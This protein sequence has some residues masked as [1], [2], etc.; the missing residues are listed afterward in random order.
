M[1]LDSHRQWTL[2]RPISFAGVSL[3]AGQPVRLTLRPAPPEHGRVFERVDLPGRPR[4]PA[5]AD[6]VVETT[7]STT[8]GEGGVRLATV[9]HLMA[10]L[11]ATGLTN[12]LIEVDGPELPI[13]DGSAREYVAAI[14]RAG[15]LEQDAPRRIITLDARL[16]VEHG[17]RSVLYQ[18]GERPGVELTC[19]V[20]YRHP[21]AGA[22]LFE[23]MVDEEVFERE[24][25]HART[26]CLFRD[27]EAMWA[28]GLALG[29]TLE[30]ALVI[31]DDGPLT[32]RRYPDE[33]VRHKVLDLLGDLALCGFD[34]QGSVVAAKAGHRLHVELAR[35]LREAA[36]KAGLLPQETRHAARVAR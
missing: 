34:W 5:L 7:L 15:R 25:A 21:H 1:Q 28:N 27:V 29:G 26:F 13:L 4:L 10:A 8:L 23:G 24:L 3:H 2:A 33:P 16:E 35:K 31:G 17:D 18:R 14:R 19:V 32:P 9:E 6:R 36:L 11:W 22:Q 30:N 20:D 12:V